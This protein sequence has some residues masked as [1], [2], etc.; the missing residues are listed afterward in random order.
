MSDINNENVP[1]F[2]EDDFFIAAV[3]ARINSL[4][5]IYG[6]LLEGAKIEQMLGSNGL[7]YLR[8]SY[9]EKEI[10]M[11]YYPV[12]GSDDDRYIL[13]LR[14]IVWAGDEGDPGMMMPCE[15]F[16]LGSPFGY[17][18][19]EPIEGV[20]ELRA[21]VPESGGMSETSQYEHV[22]DLFLYSIAELSDALE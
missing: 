11:S 19:Y 3:Q 2:T 5:T 14:S 15:S 7:P 20:V 4:E 18:V 9:G 21:Q 10:D 16:N 13:F 6:E 12:G 17:A 1:E 8:I 22:L